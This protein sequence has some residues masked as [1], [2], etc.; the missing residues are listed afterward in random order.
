MLRFDWS[1]RFSCRPELAL[2]RLLW[3]PCKA[4]TL[5]PC[6]ASGGRSELAQSTYSGPMKDAGQSVVQRLI[7]GRTRLNLRPLSPMFHQPSTYRM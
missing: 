6:H 5:V 1:W 2:Q 7:D 3:P 4:L